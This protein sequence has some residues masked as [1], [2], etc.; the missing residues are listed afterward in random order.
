MTTLPPTHWK[1]DDWS[2]ASLNQIAEHMAEH[3]PEGWDIEATFENGCFGV[4]VVDHLDSHIHAVDDFVDHPA[5]PE[6]QL[7]AAFEFAM[8]HGAQ[9]G[10]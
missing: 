7:K 1:N 2:D 5:T 10:L 3:L 9:E 8:K 4:L 6:Q